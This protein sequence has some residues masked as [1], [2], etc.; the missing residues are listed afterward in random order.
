MRRI[1]A[2]ECDVACQ[3]L[4]ANLKDTLKMMTCGEAHKRGKNVIVWTRP[5][6]LTS[7]Q[8]RMSDTSAVQ[9]FS[10]SLPAGDILS[11]YSSKE[12]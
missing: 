1:G 9:G 4:K 3:E 6:R 8:S 10:G 5:N 11:D 7:M 12:K 2:G